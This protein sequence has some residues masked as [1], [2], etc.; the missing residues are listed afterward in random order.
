MA[1]RDLAWC[2]GPVVLPRGRRRGCGGLV[3]GDARPW[4]RVDHRALAGQGRRSVCGLPRRGGCRLR[5]PDAALAGRVRILLVAYVVLFV[6]MGALADLE[7]VLAVGFGLLLGPFLVGRAPSLTFRHLTRR[8]FR[9][10]AAGFFLVA[11]AEVLLRPFTTADGP[12]AVTMTPEA[13]AEQLT[14]TDIVLGVVQ[15]VL[16]LW[17][18]RSLYKG[19][20]WAWR[21][22]VG[23]LG[24]VIVIQIVNPR[25]HGGGR[26]ARPARR[27]LGA[28]RQRARPLGLPRGTP[29][30]PQPVPP[31]GAAHQWQPRG[32]GGRRPRSRATRLLREEGTVNRLAWMTTWPE[33]R[34]FAPSSMQGYVAYRVHAGV[35]LG[36]ATRS[37]PPRRSGRSSSVSSRMP[38]TGKAWCPASSP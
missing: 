11:A 25:L 13:R 24:A 27:R 28:P 6:H 36:S 34:W 14:Q 30:L 37:A 33:N 1:A 4:L 12:F 38:C 26:G 8:D 32:A 29:R 18:A 20:R 22:A 35:A 3:G 10:L 5:H 2:G 19:R 23:L 31:P 17:L 16:W 21:W 15:A 7:H 9:L